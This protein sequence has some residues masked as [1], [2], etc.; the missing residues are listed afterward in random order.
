MT[1][2]AAAI[3]AY[4]SAKARRDCQGQHAALREAYRATHAILAR[5]PISVRAARL[6]A[7][8]WGKT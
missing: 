5:P 1:S 4:K 2:R 8:I 3:S 6:W 7:R